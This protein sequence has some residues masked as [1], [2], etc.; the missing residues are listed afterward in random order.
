MKKLEGQEN[1]FIQKK[2]FTKERP[3]K[4]KERKSMKKKSATFFERFGKK[5]AKNN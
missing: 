2:L 3:A 1:K 5:K 4:K